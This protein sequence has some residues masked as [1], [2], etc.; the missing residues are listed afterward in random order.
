M[1]APIVE[2]VPNFSEGRDQNIINQITSVIT[3]VDGANL[4]DVD[5]GQAT[6]RTV[7]TIVGEPEAVVE[8]AFRAIVKASELIDMRKHQGEHPRMGATDVCPFIPVANM[9]MEDAAACA[10][11]LG[12]RLGKETD[13]PVYIYGAAQSDSKRNNLS[14]IRSGEY[15]GFFDKISQP[16]WKPDYGKAQ[17]NAKSGATCI[18]ARDFLIAYNVNLNTKSTRIANR[19]AFDVREAGRVKRK[20]NPYTGEIVRDENGEAVRE[21]GTCKAVKAIGWFIDEYKVAQISANLTDYKV[22]PVHTFFDEVCKSA[23]SRGVRVTGSELVGLIPLKA[24]KDAGIHYLQKQ[25]RSIGISEEEIIHIAIK[26][27]GLDELGPFDPNEKI[28]EYRL[29]DLADEKL[30]QMTAKQLVYETGSESMAPGGGSISAYAGAMGAA[31]GTMVANLGANKRGWEDRVEEFSGWAEQGQKHMK[32]LLFLVDED[33]R[34][35]NRIIDAIRM[36][37]GSDEEKKSR[38]EAIEK[39]SQYATEVP[40]MVMEEAASALTLIRAMVE[41]GNPSSITDGGVGAICLQ[42]AVQG[43]YMNVKVNAKDLEDRQFA[44]AIVQRC[45]KLENSVKKEVAE[46]TQIVSEKLG[47]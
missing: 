13:I 17:M 37:K 5:P 18:G 36:P 32:Q 38:K 24:I 1:N 41:K 27:L 35:F 8:A 42:T 21:P 26:S 44:D 4:L 14:V 33:T 31:L 22:T 47:V 45:G 34:S 46:I 2:C 16:E 6:N 39:A 40:A 23:D 29:R 19:I 15:E 28:I 7:V 3:Q 10:H 12:E 20:G 25:G 43:A 30:V 11:K 9:S